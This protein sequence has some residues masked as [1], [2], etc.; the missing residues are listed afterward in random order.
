[1]LFGVC[2]KFDVN[3]IQTILSFNI[4]N[5]TLLKLLLQMYSILKSVI[6][7]NKFVSSKSHSETNISLTIYKL[8]NN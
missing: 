2:I 6:G 4:K 5:G 1:M 3:F 8:Y 7:Y